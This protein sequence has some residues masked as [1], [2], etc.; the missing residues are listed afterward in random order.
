MTIRHL[1]IYTYIL[2]GIFTHARNTLNVGTV[3]FTNIDLYKSC[4]S[5]DDIALLTARM[6]FEDLMPKPDL[7]VINND[8]FVEDIICYFNTIIRL[9]RTSTDGRNKHLTLLAIT[10]LLGGYLQHILYPNAKYAYYAGVIGFQS[11]FKVKQLFE[12]IKWFLRTNGEGWAIET[13]DSTH[14]FII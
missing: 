14:I 4:W 8:E 12:E 11:V 6:I 1:I 13:H 7:I 3:L 5:A 2:F 10:D 9:I